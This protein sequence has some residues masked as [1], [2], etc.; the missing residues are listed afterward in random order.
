MEFKTR[1]AEEGA[2]KENEKRKEEESRLRKRSLYICVCS[3]Y[4][5]AFVWGNTTS[6]LRSYAE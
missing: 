1:G 2:E 4:V 6:L 3:I 5:S